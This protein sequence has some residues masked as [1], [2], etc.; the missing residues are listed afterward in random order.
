MLKKP[1]IFKKNYFT[2]YFLIWTTRKC[3]I[4]QLPHIFLLDGSAKYSG[5]KDS[6]LATSQIVQEKIL[7]VCCK[8][9]I[10]SKEKLC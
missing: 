10:M 1:Q 8:T 4:M 6:M 9:E 7:V 5:G 2:L 3:K